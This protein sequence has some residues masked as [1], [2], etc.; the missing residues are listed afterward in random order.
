[1][2]AAV[3]EF[4]TKKRTPRLIARRARKVLDRNRKPSFE[5]PSGVTAIAA[6]ESW[7]MKM[8]TGTCQSVIG[9]RGIEVVLTILRGTI[10]S[11]L[12]CY[13]RPCAGFFIYLFIFISIFLLPIPTHRR[14]K[15]FVRLEM[16]KYYDTS[17][18]CQPQCGHVCHRLAPHMN[19]KI[20][21]A[22]QP[23]KKKKEK[24]KKTHIANYLSGVLWLTIIR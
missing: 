10:W 19:N 4:N 18:S 6:T 1:L 15:R 12:W 11:L 22:S 14:Q 24:K 5:N 20:N 3:P 17:P 8:F 9:K 7:R 16:I 21:N 2:S 23:V 13:P